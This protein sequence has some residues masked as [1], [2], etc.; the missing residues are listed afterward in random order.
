MI[1]WSTCNINASRECL[2]GVRKPEEMRTRARKESEYK[3]GANIRNANNCTQGA[4]CESEYHNDDGKF[5]NNADGVKTK[6]K[7]R[8]KQGKVKEGMEKD[9]G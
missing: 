9:L 1:S 7:S 5:V 8:N 4:I 2:T 3:N 6:P